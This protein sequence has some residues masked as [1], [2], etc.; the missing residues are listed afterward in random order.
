[1]I[2]A[3]EELG[4]GGYWGW[5][6]VENAGA[7]AVVHGHGVPALGDGPGTPRHAAGLERL[8]RHRHVLPDDLRHVHDALRR[9]AVG[10]RVRRGPRSSRAMFTVFMVATLVVS[11]GFVIYRLPLLRSRNELDSWVSREAA[12]LVNNWI[13]LFAALFVLF[14]TMFP[15]L[16]EAVNGERLT[17]GPPFFNQWMAAD[18]PDPAVPDR[19]RAAARVAQVDARRICAISSCGP[20]T[21]GARHRRRRRRARRPRL[22]SGHLLRVLRVCRRHDRCR[23][24]CAARACGA[25]T[26]GTDLF[27]AMIGLVARNKRRYGGY[28]VH[29]GIVLI[30]LGFAGNGFKQ[31]EQLLLKPG[32]RR[33]SAHYTVR[34]D[35]L[36]VTDDG[37]KQMITG[38]IDGLRTTARRSTQMYPAKW[39]FRKHEEEPTTEVA[40]RRGFAEDLYIVMPAFDVE[41]QT[42]SVDSAHQPAGQLGLAGLRRPRDRHRH[43]A[44]ARDR[45]DLRVGEAARGSGDGDACSCCASCLS[46]GTALAQHVETGQDPRLQLVSPKSREIAQKLACWC[47][48]C[49]HLPVGQCSCGMCSLER[50]NIDQML[51]EGKDEQQILHYYVTTYGGNQVLS[52]PPKTGSGSV[53]WAMPI[54]VG[55]G[56]FMTIAYLAM[57]WSRRSAFAGAP[58]APKTPKWPHAL[59]TNSAALTE[60]KE[61]LIQPWQFFLLGGMLAATATVIV[62][63]GQAPAN[64]IV[65]SVTVV[66]VASSAWARIASS[67]RSFRINLMSR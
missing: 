40:I 32:S 54:V 16:S 61:G 6:P 53:V 45:H 38:H 60:E 39:F 29:V 3:Y 67:R 33:R 48:G 34:L 66:S 23:S 46:S 52:E 50:S 35:A 47:G 58:A 30:F 44:A 21:A 43:R 36:R 2:W 65:L 4:W 14:A 10:A 1:M 62:A 17:V 27:T 24:S 56:G 55:L 18:R 57:R 5:D 11:F 49:S 25:A 64:I 20:S 59:T 37:Q 51:K 9:R 8:A 41:E 15:T 22:G 31:D 7:A 63:T 13:L 26:T 19:R 42:A 28:I 12:F